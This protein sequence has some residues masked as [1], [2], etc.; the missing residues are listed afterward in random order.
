MIGTRKDADRDGISDK[1]DKCPDT[2]LGVKV[3]SR[4]CPVDTDKDGVPD[5]LDLCPDTPK[6]ARGFVGPEGCPLDSDGDGVPDYLDKCPDSHPSARGFVDESGCP[7]DSDGDGVM[8]YM[9]RCPETPFGIAVDSV[10]C[11]IDTDA[12]G[13]PDYLDLCPETPSAARGFVDQNGCLLDTDDDGVPDYLDLCPDTPLEAR[14]F[15]DINGCLI[16]ADDD[17]VPDYRDDCPDTPFAAR[18]MVD[19]RGC[20]KDSDFDGIPDYL[21]DCPRVPGLPEFNGC[22]EIKKEVR[23]LF[24]EAMQNIQFKSDT[25]QM[26][27]SS[28]EVLDQI[29]LVLKINQN[30]N[31]EIHG[32]TD[33]QFR[34]N[35]IVELPSDTIIKPDSSVK[36]RVSEDYANLVKKHLISKG[37]NEKRLFVKGFGDTKPIATN[38]TEPGRAKNR[39]V[40]LMIVFEEVKT[41]N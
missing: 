17:G 28:Y 1:F 41:E 25:L 19:H 32:H 15:V 22:P 21:D 29:V 39:R 6:E 26:V 34:N 16:D 5:Y 7:I 30:Y 9:D 4:G 8:D 12:D 18:G 13:V 36:L 2:P 31:L 37:I 38:N 11:P 40:E 3:D 14:G 20:P 24:Q 23:I 27:E 35:Q 10:G 33:N